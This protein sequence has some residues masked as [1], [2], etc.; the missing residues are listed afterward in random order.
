[1]V[2]EDGLAVVPLL[3]LLLLVLL[4]LVLVAVEL[5]LPAAPTDPAEF[6]AAAAAAGAADADVCT[7]PL[8]LVCCSWAAIVPLRHACCMLGHQHLWQSHGAGQTASNTLAA[9][10]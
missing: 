6:V 4:L 2:P 5:T 10:S 7:L 1:M 9:I 8:L 3:L